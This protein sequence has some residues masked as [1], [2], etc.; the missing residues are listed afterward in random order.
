MSLGSR[1]HSWM[2]VSSR[3]PNVQ[4]D[5]KEVSYES[6]LLSKHSCSETT[7]NVDLQMCGAGTVGATAGWLPGF[8]VNS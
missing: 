6:Y 3:L 8:H 2:S 1:A 7:Q 5:H 4:G